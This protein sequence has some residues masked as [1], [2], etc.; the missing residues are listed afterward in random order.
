AILDML[1]NPA[2]A[3]AYVYGR[4]LL[5]PARRTPGHP[6]GGRI[7]QPRDRVGDVFTQEV[8]SIY[9]LGRICSQSGATPR[10]QPEVSRGATWGGPQR[11]S[12]DFQ[13]SCAVGDAEPCFT[14]TIRASR[15]NGPSIGVVPTR[16]SLEEQTANA[17]AR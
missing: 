5:D 3:G 8:S 16:A 11:T 6:S 15:A 17:C 14:C 10:Q 9:C 4:K 2:Y 7:L 12:L 13:G 1:H